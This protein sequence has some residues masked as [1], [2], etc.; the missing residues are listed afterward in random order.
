MFPSTYEFPS[1]THRIHCSGGFSRKV[2]S[3]VLYHTTWHTFGVCTH[4]HLCTFAHTVLADHMNL[5]FAEYQTLA[6]YIPCGAPL[7]S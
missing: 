2:S 5:F 4:S 1:A 7:F 3:V 6:D